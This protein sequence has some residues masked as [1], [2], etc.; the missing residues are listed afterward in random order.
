L[1]TI[2]KP[3]NPLFGFLSSDFLRLCLAITVF[4]AGTWQEHVSI[5]Y[6]VY[7]LTDSEFYLA[8]AFAV[9]FLPFLIVSNYIGYI[10][11]LVSRRNLLIILMLIGSIALLIMSFFISAD[12]INYYMILIYIFLSG[13]VWASTMLTQQSYSYDL[14]GY[15]Y[16]V[17][18]IAITKGADRIG[19][20]FGGVL[21]G[22]L[23]M[24]NYR[25][26]FILSGLLQCIAALILIPNSKI[27]LY[28][29]K[30]NTKPKFTEVIFLLKKNKILLTVVI[31]SC[32]TEIFGFSHNSLIPVFVKDVLGGDGQDLGMMMSFRQIGGIIGLMSIVL[33][34]SYIKKGLWLL[35]V[36]LGFGISLFILGFQNQYIYFVIISL[37]VNVFASSCD[38]LYQIITQRSV[39]NKNRGKAMGAWLFTIGSGPLGYLIIGLLTNF[40]SRNLADF[41][42]IYN[43]I[44]PQMTINIIGMILIIISF[45]SFKY[46]KKLKEVPA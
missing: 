15:K 12:F 43:S 16:S 41:T 14:T 25:F 35:F 38:S 1:N 8:V 11:D 3:V 30:N 27:S 32:G 6:I 5:G 26:P 4:A 2:K 39:D 10:S 40:I 18:G 24:K 28:S 22:I 20:M 7:E 46:A 13:S 21:S 9:R 45:I 31:L 42:S 44:G 17:K 19:G 36:I 23:V 37:V 34:G 29:P 33:L